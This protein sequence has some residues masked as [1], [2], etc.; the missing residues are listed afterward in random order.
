VA[1]EHELG[2]LPCLNQDEAP[3]DLVGDQFFE[4]VEAAALELADEQEGKGT[5]RSAP[6]IIQ[7]GI[8]SLSDIVL[9]SP[10][11]P[12]VES[13][14]TEYCEQ[15]GGPPWRYALETPTPRALLW[16]KDFFDTTGNHHDR[17]APITRTAGAS[18]V[19]NAEAEDVDAPVTRFR[20][21]RKLS[22]PGENS[23]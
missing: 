11:F 1:P 13:L 18:E 23:P 2:M 21:R 15:N 7:R 12:N 14:L 9:P 22:W 20:V 5:L 4:D 17:Q 19:P 6:Q 10:P 8:T 3:E 16:V